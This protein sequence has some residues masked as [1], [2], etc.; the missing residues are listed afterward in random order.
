MVLMCLS[1]RD[2]STDMRCDLIG[3]LRDIDLRS[4]FGLDISFF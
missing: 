4:D 2:A 3:P 1:R